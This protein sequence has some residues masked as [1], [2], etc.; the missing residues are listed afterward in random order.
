MTIELTVASEK[1]SEEWNKLVEDSPH[2][3][4]FH[5]WEWL[6]IAEKQTNSKLYPIIGYKG[7]E[8][9]GIYPLFFIRKKG[10]K[11]VFSPPSNTLLLYL[12]PA[13][14]NFDKMKQSRRESLFAEFQ[15]EVDKFV[16]SELKGNYT[17]IRTA[18]GL[19][20]S[21]PLRW[22]GY[23]VE[24]L[25][26][27]IIDITKGEEHA[28]N[29]LNRKLRVST[30]KTKREGVSVE[31]GDKE[32]LEFIR[33]SL[34]TRFEE[35]GFKPRKDYYKAYLADLYN[36]FYPENMKIFVAKYK[37]E[38]VGGL[39]VLCYKD[40]SALWIG[41]PKTEI[42]GIYPNDLAQWEAIRWTCEHGF[43]YYEEMDAGDDPRLRHF[44]A[45]FNPELAPWFS[46]TKY[47]SPVF[48]VLE[49]TTRF[50]YNKLGLGGLT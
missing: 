38:R 41:I 14:V 36:T 17:R 39:V 16:I 23:E 27:Y 42:K 46:A 6:K 31:M 30:E 43:K 1:E 22:S 20:D 25:Y 2:S 49:R 44:K 29:G 3:T 34:A 32:D 47:S 11:L 45:K 28:W 33:S 8:P 35:Q 19:L 26:T 12:G 10:I 4:I 18:P 21:R 50:V 40:W 24:P 5:R 37:G 15:T 7:T 48:K 9:I 13:F